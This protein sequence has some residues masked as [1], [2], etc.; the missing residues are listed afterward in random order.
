MN[1]IFAHEDEKYI[2]YKFSRNCHHQKGLHSMMIYKRSIFD[3]FRELDQ[4]GINAKSRTMKLTIINNTLYIS[5]QHRYI[6]SYIN[7]ELLTAIA[8]RARKISKKYF[9]GQFQNRNILNGC[10]VWSDIGPCR[11]IQTE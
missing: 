4:K 3:D 1:K 5:I 7:F 2:N 8:L 10:I 6:F 11:Q 9:S